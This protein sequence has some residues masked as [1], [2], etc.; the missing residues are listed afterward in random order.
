[1][2]DR[3]RITR[4]S[5]LLLVSM[6]SGCTFRPAPDRVQQDRVQE[7]R[8]PEDSVREQTARATERM[9]PEVEWIGRNLGYV[10]RRAAEIAI[11]AI[12][13]IWEGWHTSTPPAQG[14]NLN[15]APESELTRLPGISPREARRIAQG[16]PYR[17]KHELVTKGVLSEDQYLRLRDETTLR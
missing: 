12:Q 5:I 3:S 2:I 11:A 7:D 6:L 15:S 17:E 1:M 13:G 16:R 8:R 4:L 14:I 10:A 9:K